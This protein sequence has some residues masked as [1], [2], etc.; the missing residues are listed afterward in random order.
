MAAET[1]ISTPRRLILHLGVQK[2]GSTSLHRFLGRNRDALADRLT[3]LTPEKRTPLRALGRAATR[4]S[5]SATSE[6]RATLETAVATLR[7]SLPAG[8]TPVLISHENLP[9]AMPGNGGTTTL[10]PQLEAIL[11]VLTETFA[12]MIP[13]VV[14]YT[15]DMASWKR[16]VHA[17]AIRSDRYTKTRAEFLADTSACG[18]WEELEHRLIAHLGQ[19]RVCV[20]RLENESDD[21]RPGQQLLQQ[22]GLSDADIAGLTPITGR[23]NQSL[24]AGALEFLRLINALDL[25]RPARRAV[26]DMVRRK[27]SLFKANAA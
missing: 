1:D 27:Q 7:D 21:A 22:A 15:R 9:G 4:F 6:T 14:I 26:T 18:T 19:D 16:S 10:Y 3:V 8:D 25:D 5:L 17:Q 24:N 13:E 2:T 20:L 12:P 11:T 23:S